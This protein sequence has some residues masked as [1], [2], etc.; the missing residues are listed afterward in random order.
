MVYRKH[1]CP[2]L[3]AVVALIR[4]SDLRREEMPAIARRTQAPARP[5]GL[6]NRRP[7]GNTWGACPCVHARRTAR[8]SGGA[9]NVWGQDV[10]RSTSYRSH[11]PVY[12]A[13]GRFSDWPAGFKAA[14]RYRHPIGYTG[15]CADR[16]CAGRSGMRSR[17]T[18]CCDAETKADVDCDAHFRGPA[19]SHL[20]VLRVLFRIADD[21]AARHVQRGIDTRRLGPC[22][23]DI[24]SRAAP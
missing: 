2:R 7:S 10:R 13:A 16:G 4:V 22:L 3:R 24:P 20:G 9:A 23:D 1:P 19:V 18:G 14:N 12:L 8:L 11:S 5:G 15:R 6:R 17:R 21:E